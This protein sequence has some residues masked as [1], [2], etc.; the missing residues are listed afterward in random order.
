MDWCYN[1]HYKHLQF[2]AKPLSDTIRTFHFKRL[3]TI[4]QTLNDVCFSK[5]STVFYIMMICT[6]I[7]YRFIKTHM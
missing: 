7:T 4:R 1:C 5:T 6:E 3:Y 2:T